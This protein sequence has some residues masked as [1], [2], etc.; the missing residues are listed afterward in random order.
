MLTDLQA[1][2]ILERIRA[3]ILRRRPAT[4]KELAALRRPARALAPSERRLGALAAA[5]GL[6][7]APASTRRLL[8]HLEREISATEENA[9]V[10]ETGRRKRGRPRAAAAADSAAPGAAPPSA[11]IAET[12]LSVREEWLEWSGRL[13]PRRR[14]EIR[15]LWAWFDSP[16]EGG[17]ANSG[18]QAPALVRRLTRDAPFLR[19]LTPYRALEL[20]GFDMA[21]PDHARQR[22][23]FR[24]GLLEGA[25]G[26]SPEAYLRALEAMARLSALS[27]DSLRAIGWTLALFA[28]AAGARDAEARQA[29]LCRA[30]PECAR[31][32]ARELCAFH[33]YGG[34]E[35][36][37]AQ[38]A[39]ASIKA[40][41]P[42]DRP[43]ERLARDGP[44]SLGDADL[45]AI[46]LRTGGGG[47]NA[48]D[49][50]GAL[51]RRFE[52]LER[53][54]HASI[55]DLM[56]V[57]GVG[58][59]KAVEIRAAIELGKRALRAPLEP[60]RR[61]TS[62]AEVYEALRG[63]FAGEKREQFLLLALNN[64]NEILRV[65]TVSIGNLTQSLVHPREVFREAIR[66]AAAAVICVHNHPSGDPAPSEDDHLVTLKLRRA[67]ELL[68]IRVLDHIIVGRESY[69]SFAD[70]G[71]MG[72]E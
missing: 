49:L 36:E 6:D 19:G 47:R 24:L 46:T 72:S 31:C 61:L 9:P 20:T 12:P 56:T 13:T 67:G 21:P 55:A 14:E 37:S 50:A 68:G 43:R 18:P 58:R 59:A 60:G 11:R 44:E 57:K 70:E 51:L 53:L 71:L 63:R 28:G 62:S 66:E 10:S 8:L 15:R 25:P 54:A 65:I 64:K 34:G 40:W 16:P 23:L 26:A 17:G 1:L 2:D 38:A 42:G 45:L 52:T 29:A 32:P 30:Q 3:F 33:K 41:R 69:F 5:L 7:P 4:E 27:G 35:R 22:P 39:G 48:L